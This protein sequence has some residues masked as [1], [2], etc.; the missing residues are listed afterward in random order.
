LTAAEQAGQ[1]G[2]AI[3]LFNKHGISFRGFRSPYLK[4]NEATLKAVEQAG[5]EY[6]S[7]LPFY[8]APPE[9][10]AGI[11]ASEQDGLRRGLDFYK[12]VK[13]PA[14]RSLPRLIRGLVEIPVS[15]P[16]D[17]ILLDRVGMDPARIG[18]VWLEMARMA[19]AR[20]ELLT[21]QLHPERLTILRDALCRTLEFA[22]TGGDF[23]IATLSEIS[24]WW[25]GRAAAN[26]KLTSAGRDLYRIDLEGS[27]GHDLMPEVVSPDGRRE[28]LGPGRSI[29]AEMMPIIG[30]G[31]GTSQ[32][33]RMHLR[34]H[35]Y[36][37]DITDDRQSCSVFIERDVEDRN[38]E[39]V[40]AG[41]RGPLIR[42]ERW[43]RPFRAAMAIT[44]DIDCL[45]LGDFLRRFR[46][47]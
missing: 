44:G 15:L 26:V 7:N 8:W 1:I 20:G 30:L 47:D 21:L 17:E 37:F 6:D 42:L 2:R 41:A 31:P 38:L 45:T 27:G 28:A 14:E 9:F 13:Y 23:W 3:D 36:L 18:D 4:Y 12:P 24:A 39:T 29:A 40:L 10:A 33:F 22:R 19:L 11:T 46:E 25:R 35:G 5:F 16:D 43:P 32:D 34:N